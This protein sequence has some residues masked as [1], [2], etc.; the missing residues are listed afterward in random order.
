MGDGVSQQ[1]R[2]HVAALGELILE[3]RTG[4]RTQLNGVAAAILLRLLF[5]KGQLVSSESIK[6]MLPRSGSDDAVYTH[7][8]KLNSRLKEHGVAIP[9]RNSG[10]Y[11]LP[12]DL[13]RLDAFEFPERVAALGK[14]PHADEVARLLAMWRGDPLQVHHLVEP[15]HWTTAL[16]AR[17]VLMTGVSELFR[18]GVEVEG[19]DAFADRFGDDQ[20][21]KTADA[22][23][24]GGRAAARRRLLI[25]E[26][27]EQICRALQ[28]LLGDFDTTVVH[29]LDEYYLLM[30]GNP[31]RFHGALV[32]RHLTQ[33]NNDQYGYAALQDLQSRG[34]PRILITAFFP[35]GDVE[36]NYRNLIERFG[37]SGICT[38][39]RPDVG[40][41]DTLAVREAVDRMLRGG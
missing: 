37:L 5:Q 3:S 26:D 13:I 18:R 38:K 11:R 10:G 20:A 40:G 34:I 19:W 23:H 9:R 1:D 39:A 28:T 15:R 27:D 8:G 21:V 35:D 2:P 32:D 36:V 6:A 22:L 29:S 4:G 7:V 16:K 25:V 33:R 17:S 24:P 12:K 14:P 30:R 31:P 41:F